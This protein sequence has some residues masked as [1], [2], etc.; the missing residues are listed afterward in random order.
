M[1]HIC[2]IYG[3]YMPH[4]WAIYAP[5]MGHICHIYGVMR[6]D[7]YGNDELEMKR[8]VILASLHGYMYVSTRTRRT[9][10]LWRYKMNN[11]SNSKQTKY[12]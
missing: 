4:I 8:S 6:A 7:E 1:G 5:Y 11:Y 12:Y 3:P 2:H 10:L 9:I